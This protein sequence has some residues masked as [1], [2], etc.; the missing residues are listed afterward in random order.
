MRRGTKPPKARLESKLPVARKSRQ[1]EGSGV[2]H[3]E[4]RLA[5]ALKREAEALTVV[6]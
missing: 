6:G 4:K 2:R 5:E 1:N 3:L